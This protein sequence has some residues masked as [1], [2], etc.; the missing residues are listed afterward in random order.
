MSGH[1]ENG[2]LDKAVC[3]VIGS[4]SSQACICYAFYFNSILKLRAAHPLHSFYLRFIFYI[5]TIGRNRPS[6]TKKKK[7]RKAK[8][9]LYH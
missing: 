2:P 4:N 6:R 9:E 8:T 7:E 3:L 5:L 1:R